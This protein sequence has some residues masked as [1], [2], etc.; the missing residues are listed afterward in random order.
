MFGH[1]VQHQTCLMIVVLAAATTTSG[2]GSTNL[3][4]LAAVT[5]ILAVAGAYFMA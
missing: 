4:F 5:A 3:T 2:A 1:T